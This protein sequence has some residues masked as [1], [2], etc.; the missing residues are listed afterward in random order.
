MFWSVARN[1]FSRPP[2]NGEGALKSG[3]PDP[4]WVNHETITT[5]SPG[6][7]A[8]GIFISQEGHTLS[9][10]WTWVRPYGQIVVGAAI[11]VLSGPGVGQW[12][13]VA[14]FRNGSGEGLI[15]LDA[16]FDSFVD[17]SSILAVVPRIGAK[18]VAGNNF[19]WTGV[20]QFYGTTLG[21]V[22]A[23]NTLLNVNVHSQYDSVNGASLRATGECYYGA[24][25]NF[26]TEMSGNTLVDSD[27]VGFFNEAQ[28]TYMGNVAMCNIDY[29]QSVP[30]VRWGVARHNS[31]SGISDAA[32]YRNA[33]HPACGG[34]KVVSDRT[35][36]DDA[37]W[38]T[39]VVTEHNALS[40]PSPGVLPG[41][42]GTRPYVSGGCSHC[43]IAGT[44]G[45]V[46]A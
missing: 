40:C 41:V 4:N 24:Q 1:A 13:T 22:F 37:L 17:A 8:H 29:G 11:I 15:T 45:T 2:H 12:R 3:E 35:G 14:A 31:I 44:N 38:P 20:I 32:R 43:S 18:V 34:V 26:F 33:T 23:D 46:V 5:D 6:E 27:G 39:D 19:S 10:N 9:T 42:N 28:K 7:F 16:P 30:W 21:G 36:P 25:P